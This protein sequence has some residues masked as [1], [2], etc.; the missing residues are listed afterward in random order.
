[1]TLFETLLMGHILGDWIFQTEWQATNKSSNWR[2]MLV[3]VAV[4]HVIMLG[5]LVM[6]AGPGDWRIYIAVLL[7]AITHAIL[8]RR[9][10]VHGLMRLLRITVNRPPEKWLAI[11]IDQAVHLLLLGL[12]AF[13]LA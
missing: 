7:L 6:W 4:Y 9:Q 2:A 8:D 3:H 5:F 1:M 10:S 11:P 12:T 13:L